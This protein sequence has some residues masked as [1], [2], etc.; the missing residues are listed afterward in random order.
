MRIE[1]FGYMVE[2][3]VQVARW[4]VAHL[5]FQIRRQQSQSPWAHFL[6]DATGRVMLEIYNNPRAVVPDYAAMDP[7]VLHLA[8]SVHDVPQTRGE[9][10]AGGAS[11]EGEITVTSCGDQLAMLRDPWGMAIQLVKRAEPMVF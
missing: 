6:A 7:L 5:G 10:L 9:L 11:A 1:H 4:Y 3:P 8:F 2:D